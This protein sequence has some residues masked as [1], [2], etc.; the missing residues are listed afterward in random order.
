MM[1]LSLDFDAL[2]IETFETSSHMPAAP[3]DDPQFLLA[4]SGGGSC[5][6]SWCYGASCGDFTCGRSCTATCGGECA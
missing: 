2:Q 5:N 6:L 3:Q 1:K 4:I